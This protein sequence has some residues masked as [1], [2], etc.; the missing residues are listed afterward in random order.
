MKIKFHNG[1][2]WQLGSHIGIYFGGGSGLRRWWVNLNRGPGN[3]RAP[4]NNCGHVWPHHC[5]SIHCSQRWCDAQRWPIFGWLFV[6]GHSLRIWVGPAYY[7]GDRLW[8]PSVWRRARQ[9]LTHLRLN[10]WRNR[11]GLYSLISLR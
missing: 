3:A 8:H 10:R 7:K 9:C 11:D 5:N 2:G 1:R 4:G 6:L